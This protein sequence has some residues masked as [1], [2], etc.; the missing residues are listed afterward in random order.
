MAA[1][2]FSTV[3]SSLRS[4]YKFNEPLLLTE[5]MAG[6]LKSYTYRCLSVTYF[7]A[8]FL[9]NTQKNFR[10]NQHPSHAATNIVVIG[11]SLSFW[12]ARVPIIFSKKK[13]IN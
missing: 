4:E 5:T 2:S 11:A 12:R 9:Y 3:L 6:I 13:I 7:F 8:R 10:F 1:V